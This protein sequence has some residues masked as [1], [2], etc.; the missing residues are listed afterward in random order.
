MRILVVEDDRA[1]AR[2]ITRGLAE[3]GYAIDTVHTISGARALLDTAD[4]ALVVLDLG[5]PDGNGVDF[6]V[7]LRDGGSAVKILML[8]ARDGVAE[9]IIGLN[10]GAD[11]YL[12]KPFDFGELGARLGSSAL[13]RGKLQNQLLGIL[14]RKFCHE[15]QPF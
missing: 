4:V 7:E 11:D 2:I 13:S 3:D 10:A 12:P 8:T 1:L 15:T 14:H 6:C 9:R 5:L